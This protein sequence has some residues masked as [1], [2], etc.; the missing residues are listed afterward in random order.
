MSS[1]FSIG[2]DEMDLDDEVSR[3]DKKLRSTLETILITIKINFNSFALKY[4]CIERVFEAYFKDFTSHVS[5]HVL[6]LLISP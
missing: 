1:L 6:R 4:L 3:A 2:E 5:L